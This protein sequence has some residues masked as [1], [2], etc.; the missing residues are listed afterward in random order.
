MQGVQLDE[1]ISCRGTEIKL[2]QAGET[3]RRKHFMQGTEMKAYHAGGTDTKHIMQGTDIKAYHE[4]QRRVQ[5]LS[6]RSHET[7]YCAVFVTCAYFLQK[8]NFQIV[9]LQ[10]DA[11]CNEL[12]DV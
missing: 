7:S 8:G 6:A 3:A 9:K 1:I 10:I 2:Y 11:G 4:T 5:F 12:F